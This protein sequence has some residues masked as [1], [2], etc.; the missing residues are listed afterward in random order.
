MNK[1]EFLNQEGVPQ[2]LK[3]LLEGLPENAEVDVLGMEIG[4]KPTAK[5]EGHKC[6]GC[7]EEYKDG[8]LI[9]PHIESLYTQLQSMGEI[10]DCKGRIRQEDVAAVEGIRAMMEATLDA[11]DEFLRINGT[12]K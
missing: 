6:E 5:K 12:K 4:R 2:F 8:I 1:T 10:A 9:A 11:M 7:K 3:D